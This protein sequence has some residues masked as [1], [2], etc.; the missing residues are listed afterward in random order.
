[1][2]ILGRNPIA[3]LNGHERVDRETDG[4]QSEPRKSTKDEN[5]CASDE[6]VVAKRELDVDQLVHVKPK[7]SKHRMLHAKV[8]AKLRLTT[9]G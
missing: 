8:E 9:E 7:N 1:M 4:K 6:L 2:A 3:Y 5:A